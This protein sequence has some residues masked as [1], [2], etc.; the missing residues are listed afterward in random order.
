MLRLC[1]K[2]QKNSFPSNGELLFFSPGAM[3]YYDIDDQ[4][5]LSVLRKQNRYQGPNCIMRGN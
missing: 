2:I 5:R 3:V 1:K 4:S